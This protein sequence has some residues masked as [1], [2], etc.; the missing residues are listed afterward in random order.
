MRRLFCGFRPDGAGAPG[1]ADR[2]RRGATTIPDQIG[3]VTQILN[4][5]SVI[6]AFN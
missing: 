4:S 2:V 1:R 5:F 6:T 3:K